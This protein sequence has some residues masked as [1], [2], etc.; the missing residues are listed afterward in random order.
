MRVI[1]AGGRYFEDMG[2]LTEFMDT[3]RTNFD[4]TEIVHGGAKGADMLGEAWALASRIPTRC[5]PADWQKHGLRAGPIRNAEMAQY[6]DVLVAF[7]DGES[8]GTK[9]MIQTMKQAGKLAIVVRYDI[10]AAEHDG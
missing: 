1:I 4:I 6:A 2:L 3:V 5:F 10:P 8:K 9:N 7:W